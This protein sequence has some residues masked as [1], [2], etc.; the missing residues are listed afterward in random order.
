MVGVS[1]WSGH[2][3]MSA[4]CAKT[5][6]TLAYRCTCRTMSSASFGRKLILNCAYNAISAIAKLLTRWFSRMKVQEISCGW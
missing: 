4:K 3:R 1:L 6:R 2:Q 5:S